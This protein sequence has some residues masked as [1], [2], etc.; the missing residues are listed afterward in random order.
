MLIYHNSLYFESLIKNA[1]LFKRPGS[2]VVRHSSAK[3]IYV[4]AIPTQASLNVLKYFR[5]ARVAELVYAHDL[6]S[7]PARDVGSMPTSG[8]VISLNRI[9]KIS[10]QKCGEL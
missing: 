2:Q 6:R 10:K 3:G 7:C 1:R 4:G 8:T 9:R 5:N